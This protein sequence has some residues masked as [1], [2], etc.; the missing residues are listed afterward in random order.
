MKAQE[1]IALTIGNLAMEN[2][3]LREQLEAATA[4]IDR[5]LAGACASGG[6]RLDEGDL[7]PPVET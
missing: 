5:D 7:D 2:C 3:S 4:R 6:R 1:Q